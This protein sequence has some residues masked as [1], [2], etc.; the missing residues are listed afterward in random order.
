MK[1]YY[2]FIIFVSIVL[3]F[4]CKKYPENTLVLDP[5]QA[6]IRKWNGLKLK[7]FKVNGID[8]LTLLKSYEPGID[9]EKFNCGYWERDYGFKFYSEKH[10]LFIWLYGLDNMC[11]LQY[12][13][14]NNNSWTSL[15]NNPGYFCFV[16]SG[17]FKIIKLTHHEFKI[18]KTF[19]N[20]QYEIWFKK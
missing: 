1:I 3:L 13:F 2:N 18:S 14:G 19:K 9:Q 20:K 5:P 7:E 16:V 8:S 15:P 17:S 11:E 4:G 6:V 12:C 10:S